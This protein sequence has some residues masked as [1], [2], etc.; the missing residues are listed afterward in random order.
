[1]REVQ[2]FSLNELAKKPGI[3]KSYLSTLEHDKR[4]PS[5]HTVEKLAKSLK[6]LTG[7]L[8]YEGKKS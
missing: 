1:M 7:W 4:N 3:T 8:A 5:M 6:I 2:E